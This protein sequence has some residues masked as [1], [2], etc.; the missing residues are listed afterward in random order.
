[1]SDTIINQGEI[2]IH[3]TDHFD[4]YKYRWF[5]LALFCSYACIN[6]VQYLQYSIIANII[7]RY[8]DIDTFTVN[9][10]SLVFMISYI[11]LFI[12]VSYLME[13][14]NLR[15]ISILASCLTACGVGIRLFSVSPDSFYIVLIGQSLAAVAQVF[16]M[17]LPS[18]LAAV[19]FGSKEVSTACAFAVLGTQ[20]GVAFGC[21]ISPNVVKNHDD[22]DLIGEE[23]FGLIMYN[24]IIA[25]TICFLVVVFFEARP[26]T[27]PS[28]SQIM[29]G[30]QRQTAYFSSLKQLVKNKD[31]VL[32]LIAIGLSN[33]IW[34]AFG[35][36][37]NSIYLNYFPNG[38]EDAGL[39]ALIA[40]VSGGCVGSLLFGFILDKTHK[41]KLTTFTILFL[42]SIF[43]ILTAI[44]LEKQ[45]R[46]FTFITGGVFG[47]FLAGSL[48]VGFEYSA[49]VAYPEP[50]AT[51]LAFLNAVILFF[52]LIFSVAI[53]FLSDIIG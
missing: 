11:V 22:I 42:S 15:Q 30:Q 46:I 50:E 14:L 9:W 26:P 27:P 37:L 17:S 34:N 52:G 40:V 36:E 25:Y 51:A 4:L 16:I 29:V 47:F 38:E 33:G 1:M 10:T 31:Y 5:I 2:P 48:V 53:D 7:S 6:F 49:E 35:I 41:F 28:Y 43:F 24:S 23:L 32:L 8:Y 39:L 20:L 13:V 18:K 21:I 12:P 45:H 44:S 19:W 3:N